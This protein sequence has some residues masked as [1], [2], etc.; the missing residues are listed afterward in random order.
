PHYVSGWY[1]TTFDTP[2]KDGNE[3]VVLKFDG[4]AYHA[5]VFVNGK[6]VGDHKG[7]FTHFEFTVDDYLN[8]EGSENTLYVWISNDFGEAPPRHVYGKMFFY[9]SNMGG[10]EQPVYLKVVPS[11]RLNELRIDPNIQEQVVRFKAKTVYNGEDAEE[12]TAVVCVTDIYDNI[13]L[14]NRPAVIK[15]GYITGD[16]AAAS[17]E[18][19]NVDNPV[20]Y[21]LIVEIADSKGKIIS[22]TSQKFGYRQFKAEGTK[23]YLNGNRV[24]L[25]FGNIFSY[26]SARYDKP[27]GRRQFIDWLL[28]QKAQGVNALR[29]HMAGPNSDTILDICDEVGIL[30][31]QEFHMFHRVFS[32][33]PSIDD[34][35]KFLDKALVE[36]SEFMYR[37]YNHPSVVVWSLSN[38]VWSNNLALLYE[39]LYRVG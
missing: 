32:D 9:N 12:M 2:I 33:I 8:P 21:N 36:L 17:L 6:Y 10:I 25:Y 39:E 19:W 28:R 14:P 15:D 3:N 4:A 23:F 37:D 35:R 5:L 29:Y 31:M 22:K 30:V 20:I 34:Q 18:L 38:E 16:I 27:Q 7:S 1:K 13:I 26:S 11:Y 24:K